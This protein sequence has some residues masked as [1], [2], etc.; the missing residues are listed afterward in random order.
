V[1]ADGRGN[2]SLRIA[3]AI[4]D[5][6]QRGR[7]AAGDSLPGTRDLARDLEVNRK[8]VVL[9]Y[10]ELVAQGW[11]TTDQRRGTF[12]SRN[13]SDAVSSTAVAR[14][15][16]T[17]MAA[18]RGRTVAPPLLWPRRGAVRFDDGVPDPR[19]I[20][21]TAIAQ[22]YAGAARAAARLRLLTYGDPRG[23]E[24]LRQSISKMLNM[25]RGLST[26]PNGICVTRGSQMALYVIAQCLVARDDTVIF[27][28]LTY[29][30][31]VQAFAAAGARIASVRLG[32]DGIDLDHLE[33][34]CRRTRVRA[35]YLTPGHQFPT[36]VVMRPSVRLRLRALAAQ[37]GFFVV[38]DDYDHEFH[39]DH[40]P[41][42]PL[43]SNDT[44]GQIVYVGSFSK[45]LSPSLRVGYVAGPS[46][47]IEQ[48]G[49]WIGTI[50]RQGDPITELA[51]VELIESGQLRRHIKRVHAIFD[52]RRTAFADE[53]T[54]QLDGLATFDMPAGGLAFWVRF[55]DGLS[56]G[57]PSRGPQI[58]TS[59]ECAISGTAAPAARLGFAG[60]GGQ[61]VHLALSHL[62]DALRAARTSG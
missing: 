54:A 15:T 20:P 57:D 49:N 56:L 1:R 51:I 21:T 34:V 26:T 28:E 27:E 60:L 58:L 14:D 30:P 48:I 19:L 29:P 44:A 17:A 46:Q 62:R 39:F 6:I 3:Q 33:D 47:L 7:L 59:A 61:E 25:T 41:M 2:L 55:A 38:E 45:V 42:F 13:I 53:L 22:A 8:T 12:V 4:I 5:D 43:A 18:P 35:I 16:T 32:P 31:A 10:E 11:V 50:D 40:Q 36:T 52:A 23:T 24:P 9:A 37:F